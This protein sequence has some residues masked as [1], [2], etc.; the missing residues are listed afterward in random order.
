MVPRHLQQLL[1]LLAL[2]PQRRPA[3]GIQPGHEQRT[4]RALA[5]PAGEQCRAAHLLRDDPHDLVGVRHQQL[6]QPFD[7]VAVWETEGDAVVGRHR[8]HVHARFTRERVA[9]HQRPRR[10]HAASERRMDHHAPIAQLIAEALHHDGGVVGHRAGGD[11]LLLHVL[12]KVGGGVAVHV[13]A[14]EPGGVAADLLVQ[15][16]DPPPQFGRA[17]LV[18]AVP[19]RQPPRV[20]RRGGDEHLISG[21]LLDAPRRRAQREDVA[22]ARFEDHLLI[23]FTDAPLAR[24]VAD[25]EHPE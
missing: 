21:D 13:I 3:P 22:D 10:Q 11:A 16:A 7:G 5:E 9:D 23:Q 15:L 19:E 25:Q 17:A 6:R 14:T 20:T 18:F 24:F 4:G 12:S 1:G 8:P 2:L